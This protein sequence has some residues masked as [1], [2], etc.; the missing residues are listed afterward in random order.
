MEYAFKN[1][2]NK[3]INIQK[4]N[5][6][7]KIPP[8]GIIV[9]EPKDIELYKSFF[10]K[11]CEKKYIDKQYPNIIHFINEVNNEQNV[12][13]PS[14]DQQH[15]ETT[16]NILEHLKND[17]NIQ[18]KNVCDDIVSF[19]N[20][21]SNL[22]IYVCITNFNILDYKKIEFLFYRDKPHINLHNTV[23]LFEFNKTSSDY[24]AL[25]SKEKIDI[26]V[27][28]KTISFFNI[29]MYFN[30]NE[31]VKEQSLIF[32]IS[33]ADLNDFRFIPYLHKYFKTNKIT[34]RHFHIID[35]KPEYLKNLALESKNKTDNIIFSFVTLVNNKKT[36]LNEINDIKKQIFFENIE[37]IVIPN[38][39]NEFSS[40]AEPLNY[41]INLADGK[42]I[43][44]CHQDLL[45][46]TNV[47][48]MKV[49]Y[50]INHFEKNCIN[51][52]VVGI[53]GVKVLES[54]TNEENKKPENF[55]IYPFYLV[56]K[57]S[58]LPY[59]TTI[60][61]CS[62]YAEVQT[63]DELCL[64]IK[65]DKSLYFDEEML[66]HYHFYGADICLSA[67]HQGKKNF[68][69]AAECI[70]LS[71]GTGNLINESQ[72]EHFCEC[73]RRIAKKWCQYFDLIATTTS[74]FNKKEKKIFLSI[75]DIINMKKLAK[76]KFN[77]LI[78][79]EK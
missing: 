35:T 2:T 67:I 25:K 3:Y 71:D 79:F 58:N 76:K 55:L 42:Y 8:Q 20:I 43:I 69:I 33:Y 26:I 40:C 45:F 15:I 28:N 17:I 57:N 14:N 65:N 53:A 44:L 75:Y 59:E 72:Y 5:R 27:E 6:I 22:N 18:L 64:I 60:K 37:I 38:F 61:N 34:K 21:I 74:I 30:N 66:Y 1:I 11:I 13:K 41:G 51:W 49:H 32:F 36:Y 4:N 77:V 9:C 10:R 56:D 31:K 50:F 48:L 54:H 23:F 73:A 16:F 29:D 63:I 46:P 12:L 47:W 68:C 78:P 62:Y 24:E 7:I 70:H 52:G 39:N 19:I